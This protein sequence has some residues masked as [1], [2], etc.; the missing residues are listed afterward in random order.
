MLWPC[1]HRNTIFYVFLFLDGGLR[2]T[3]LEKKSPVV[4]ILGIRIYK[5][6]GLWPA[7]RRSGKGVK[8]EDEGVI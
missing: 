5:R 2:V 7:L 6:V 3:W 4:G 8:R 1:S